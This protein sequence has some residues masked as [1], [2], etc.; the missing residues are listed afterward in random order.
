[1]DKKSVFVAASLTAGRET[2]PFVKFIV[3]FLQDAGYE[4]P[5]VH[6]AGDDPNQTFCDK[7]QDP[8]AN[9]DHSF[10]EWDNKWIEEAHLFVA[11]VTTPSHGVGGEFE[12]CRI[13]E[14]LG[15]NRTPMLCVSLEG[16][17]VSPYITGLSEEEKPWIW[18]RSY[19]NT[20]DLA[21]TLREF[22]SKHD[23]KKTDPYRAFRQ[24]ERFLPGIAGTAPFPRD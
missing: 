18:F 12:H 3:Q 13:K 16:R 19:R 5:S 22:L 8:A 2:L 15:L 1:M 24:L 4:V 20:E 17:T 6:N 14:R 23:R 11:E 21:S 10:R 9:N 7:I